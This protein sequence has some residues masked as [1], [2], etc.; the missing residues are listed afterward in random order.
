MVRSTRRSIA[1]IAQVIAVVTVVTSHGPV[2]NAAL[3]T[4]G[5]KSN[6]FDGAYVQ[7]L[8]GIEGVYGKITTRNPAMCGTDTNQAVVA[9]VMLEDTGGIGGRWAQAGFGKPAPSG[10]LQYFSQ[11]IKGDGSVA[12]TK[13]VPTT[14]AVPASGSTHSYTVKWISSCGAN[15]C[16]G[17]YYDSAQINVTSFNPFG[18]WSYPFGWQAMGEAFY[19]ES[20]VPG[21][22]PAHSKFSQIQVQDI[23]TN[24]FR[25]TGIGAPSMINHSSRWSNT[26][27][28]TDAT[29]GN[30][31]DIWTP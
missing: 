30:N 11:Y 29:Y 8:T 2:A 20:D 3:S 17:F 26:A 7:E 6:W 16:L 9:W 22:A 12:V 5:T 10:T 13:W 23:T 24:A 21:T 27:F 25:A 1:R 19:R 14:Q 4:C 18:T 28:S 15:P 31:F